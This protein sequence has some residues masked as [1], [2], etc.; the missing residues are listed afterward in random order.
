[1][2]HSDPI[3]AAYD[4]L[5][6]HHRNEANPNDSKRVALDRARDLERIAAWKAKRLL[7]LKS[8]SHLRVVR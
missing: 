6:E 7:A 4:L 5:L 8:G 1:M 3:V 2:T